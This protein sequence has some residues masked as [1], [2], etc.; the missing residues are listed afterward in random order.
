M[1]YSIHSHVM[2]W[3]YWELCKQLVS[4]LE[5]QIFL[6]INA[7]VIKMEAFLV[8]RYFLYTGK[9]AALLKQK[10]AGRKLCQVIREEF[11]SLFL[12]KC[13]C[14]PS[15]NF[16]NKSPDLPLGER[17]DHIF[18]YVHQSRLFN[19]FNVKSNQCVIDFSYTSCLYSKT[20]ITNTLKYYNRQQPLKK[21]NTMSGR[22]FQMQYLSIIFQLCPEACACVINFSGMNHSLTPAELLK[23]PLLLH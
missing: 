23:K 4:S 6:L 17:T 3:R 7:N 19:L 14:L 15:R 16:Q 22:G 12:C 18:H 1:H 13:D 11:L 21:K 10:K 2:L 5:Y 20:V 8:K 9:K